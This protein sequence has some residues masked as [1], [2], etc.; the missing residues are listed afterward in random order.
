MPLSLAG[1]EVKHAANASSAAFAS[2]PSAAESKG[3]YAVGMSQSLAS[4]GSS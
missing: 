1:P 4:F 3:K 2:A